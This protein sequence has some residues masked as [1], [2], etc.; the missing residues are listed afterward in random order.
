MF[1]FRRN[2]PIK[3]PDPRPVEPL[4]LDEI[5]GNAGL[6]GYTRLSIAD[7]ETGVRPPVEGDPVWPYPRYLEDY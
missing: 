6:D 4:V 3:V 7:R 1:G 2:Q 5:S